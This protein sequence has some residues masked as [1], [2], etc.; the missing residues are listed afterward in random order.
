MTCEN[1]AALLQHVASQFQLVA[2]PRFEVIKV[3]L[4][5]PQDL[6]EAEAAV[7]RHFGPGVSALFLQGD[8]CRR[9]LLVEIDGMCQ[10]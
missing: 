9:E 7:E 4:R 1:I 6:A 10:L 8:I 2:T 3:Y 5:N